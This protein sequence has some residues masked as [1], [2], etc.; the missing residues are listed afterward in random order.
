[1]MKRQEEEDS[2]E[3]LDVE[4][5]LKTRGETRF[6]GEEEEDKE[7]KYKMKRVANRE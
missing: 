1:M 6:Y 7:S 2:S 3:R 5:R 4:N